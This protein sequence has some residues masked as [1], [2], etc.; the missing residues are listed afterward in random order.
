MLA[1]IGVVHCGV[2]GGFW[3]MFWC[4]LALLGAQVRQP[5]RA[6]AKWLWWLWVYA[7][8]VAS[9]PDDFGVLKNLRARKIGIL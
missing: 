3:G 7:E 9:L 2:F 4:V 1:S 5:E 8:S 6:G